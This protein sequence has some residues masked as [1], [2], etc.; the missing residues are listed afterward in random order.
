MVRLALFLLLSPD[1]GVVDPR[2][3]TKAEVEISGK[4]DFPKGEGN[5]RVYV[6]TGGCFTPAMQV[7]SSVQPNTDGGFFSEVFVPQGTKLWVCA[8]LVP[9]S[10]KITQWGTADKA[11][12]DG[13]GAG[14]VSIHALIK[15]AKRAP[16]D[17]PH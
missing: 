14:E 5:R 10:G 7:L 8:A 4:A 15:V 9:A 12:F 6:A 2:L 1:G 11:P 3:P 16:V 13:Q 17:R